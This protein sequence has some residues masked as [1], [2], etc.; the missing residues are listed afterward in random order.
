MGKPWRSI[1][2][3]IS[4]LRL[5][6]TLA[7]GQSFRWK[8]IQPGTWRSVLSG[9][10]WTLKQTD[11]HILYQVH[12][13]REDSKS[14]RCMGGSGSGSGHPATEQ[15]DVQS[16]SKKRSSGDE[17]ARSKKQRRTELPTVASESPRVSASQDIREHPHGDRHHDIL[18]DYFQLDVRLAGLYEQWKGA[19]ENFS[20]VSASFPGVRILRQNPVENLVSFICSSNNNIS[21]ITGMV[22][23]L[24][25]HYGTEIG[26]LDGVAWHAFP[27][28]TVLGGRGVEERLRK[29]GFGY[30][31]KF[32]NQTAK[33]ITSELGGEE[34]LWKLRSLPYS[35]VHSQLLQ[36]PGVGAKVADCVCLMSLDKREAIPVDTH[37]WQIAARDYMTSLQKTKSLTDRTYREIGDFFR[38]LFGEYAGWAHSVLFSADLKKF[39]DKSN[40]PE[41]NKDNGAKEKKP[42]KNKRS[43]KTVKMSEVV[44]R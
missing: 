28:L 12:D 42:L 9:C 27:T 25:Q 6:I 44:A 22:E 26:V 32:I 15:T 5:D 2:C 13:P 41:K 31:A 38:E 16:R 34:W 7:C 37:V 19:D 24:C 18:H 8:E 33:K 39:Q 3:G 29:L 10:I 21:R 43:R 36:L 1:P 4:E 35:E 11:T 40:T 17:P 23:K 30:R 14:P 20:K